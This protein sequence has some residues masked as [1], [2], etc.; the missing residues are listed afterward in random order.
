[1]SFSKEA[2][3]ELNWIKNKAALLDNDELEAY[4]KI[5]DV[6]IE[7][8]LERAKFHKKMKRFLVEE[9]ERRGV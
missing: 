2:E 9:K 1:M 5:Q 7:V 8:A 4:I 3:K 6:Y